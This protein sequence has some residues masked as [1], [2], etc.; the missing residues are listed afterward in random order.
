[1]RHADRI[2]F[3]F[4]IL[5]FAALKDALIRGHIECCPECGRRLATVDEARLAIV[6]AAELGDTDRLQ[7]AVMAEIEGG[8]TLPAIAPAR[9]RS[10]SVLAPVWRWAAAAAGMFAAVMATA[11]LVL[12]FQSGAPSG[13]VVLETA[14]ADQFQITYV[15]IADEP[16]QTYIFKPHDSNI[17]IIWAGKTH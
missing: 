13:P 1:M 9:D 5:P 12:F 7:R 3:L 6:R 15:K 14:E 2:D 17:V 16:A 11:A 10:S 8:E 4:R